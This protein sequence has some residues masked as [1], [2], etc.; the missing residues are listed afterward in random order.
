M[1]RPTSPSVAF[2]IAQTLW[3]DADE[4]QEQFAEAFLAVEVAEGLSGRWPTRDAMRRQTAGLLRGR[5]VT[6][7]VIADRCE[8]EGLREHLAGEPVKARERLTT[9]LA[10]HRRAGNLRGTVA[11]AY[12]LAHL[13]EAHSAHVDAVRW[14]VAAGHSDGARAAAEDTPWSDLKH[15][16]RMSGPLWERASSYAALLGSGGLISDADATAL[17]SALIEE[18]LGPTSMQGPQPAARARAALASIVCA[19]SGDALQR[20]LDLLRIEART[21][22]APTCAEATHGLM[23]AHEA[24]L[25]DEAVVIAHL[26]LGPNRDHLRITRAVASICNS[27]SEAREFV[28]RAA[29]ADDCPQAL[30][31]AAWMELPDEDEQLAAQCAARADRAL[32]AIAEEDVQRK[33]Q[34]GVRVDV[35]V[36]HENLGFIGRWASPSSTA[37]TCTAPHRR[38]LQTRLR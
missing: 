5:R 18:A 26:M 37:P 11:L 7:T 8:A 15:V 13:H 36:Q 23:Q 27:S 10:F 31:L 14:R 16:V 29:T 2:S 38:L 32:A 1:A 3:Q 17:A 12:Q 34:K 35:H 6:P 33:K 20:A 24:G 25:S 21:Q 19:L 9:A 4:A 28:R 22:G 30:W